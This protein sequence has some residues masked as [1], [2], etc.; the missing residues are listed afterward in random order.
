LT[1]KLLRCKCVGI[2]RSKLVTQLNAV[3][4][5]NEAVSVNVERNHQASVRQLSS[6]A[7]LAVR[8]RRQAASR[9]ARE[10]ELRRSTKAAPS[11]EVHLAAGTAGS[12]AFPTR[13]DVV[14]AFDPQMEGAVADDVKTELADVERALPVQA[15]D[16]P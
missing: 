4:Y 11:I 5:S 15:C 12:T 2:Q 16:A 8:C 10:A 14:L 13:V 3:P 7:I 6:A 1:E 9:D